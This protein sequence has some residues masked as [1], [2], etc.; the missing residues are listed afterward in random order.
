M[1]RCPD[2]GLENPDDQHTCIEYERNRA[3]EMEKQIILLHHEIQTLKL[4]I[5]ELE[6]TAAGRQPWRQQQ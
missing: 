2:C 3:D 6:H 1:N 4:R 5:A